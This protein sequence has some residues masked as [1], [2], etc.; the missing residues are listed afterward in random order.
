MVLLHAARRGA[1]FVAGR[2]LHNRT[3]SFFAC[4]CTGLHKR[5]KTDS[6][7]VF[8]RFSSYPYVLKP[9]HFHTTSCE[10]VES[11][12]EGIE[13]AGDE[14]KSRESA[15][16]FQ[17]WG[18]SESDISKIFERRSSLRK[19]DIHILR[20]KLDILSRLGIK[21]ADL[22]KM[23]HCRP[24]LLN[25]R[26][27]IDLNER[28]AYLE[29]LFGSKEV[30]VKAIVRNPSLLIY[31]FQ[32]KVKPI[33]AMYESLGLSK[34]DLITVLLSRPTLI[35]R[36]NLN[37]EKLDYIR[38]TGVSERSK[39]YKHVVSI[40]AIS[41]METIREKMLSMEKYGLSEDDYLCL[42]GRSPLVMTLSVDKVQ[43]NMTYVLGTMKL[44]ASVVLH[45]PFLI[46]FNLEKVLK[47]RFL[48]ACKIEDMGLAPQ[49]KGPLLLRA[50]RMSDKRFIKAFISCHPESV[51]EE[52]L[53][54]YKHA[55]CVRR[56]HYAA[57]DRP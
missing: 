36:T 23:V 9:G 10:S 28:L 35:P 6:S 8:L 1:A 48:I 50:M 25:C 22:V 52:L 24:R 55:K 57:V 38:R 33:I 21:S 44:P 20:S 51:A 11:L 27:N 15:D 17:E 42:I 16:I 18:C 3:S 43:R 54:A 53:T 7:F 4:S 19:M 30:L 12:Q 34:E 5:Q 2:R 47:P 41:R 14:E 39:M 49:I 29:G 46:F 31:D 40:V 32:N 45:N 56:Q 13:L 37:E 26:I